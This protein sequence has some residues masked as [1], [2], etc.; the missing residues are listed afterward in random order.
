MTSKRKND[1]NSGNGGRPP[2]KPTGASG[3]S[4]ASAASAATQLNEVINLEDM[5]HIVTFSIHTLKTIERTPLVIGY[6]VSTVPPGRIT[7]KYVES[8]NRHAFMTTE[9]RVYYVLSNH[10]HP[11]MPQV[12]RCLQASDGKERTYIIFLPYF[13]VLKSYLNTHKDQPLSEAEV[14]NLFSQLVAAVEYCHRNRIALRDMKL[15]KVMFSDPEHTR[16]VI[17]DLT[18]AVVMPA[19]VNVVHDQQGSP[20]YVAPE[21]LSGRPYDPFKADIWSL[22]VMLFV[23]LSGGNYPFRDPRPAMLFRKITNGPIEVPTDFPVN[24][25]DLVLQMLTRNPAFRPSIE[26]IRQSLWVSGGGAGGAGI[27]VPVAV[28]IAVPIAVPVDVPVAVPISVPVAVPISVHVAEIIQN[29]D[30]PNID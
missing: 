17:A 7:A 21:I 19:S 14:L 8:T 16:I 15:E 22:G 28:P 29:D 2:K 25:R 10:P 20:A 9:G 23:L 11:N 13:G 4:A 6:D 18:N 27:A 26:D 5:D 1:G 30:V 3:A 24:A 12:L